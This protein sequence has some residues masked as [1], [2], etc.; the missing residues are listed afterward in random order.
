MKLSK[1]ELLVS[2]VTIIN[3]SSVRQTTIETFKEHAARIILRVEILEFYQKK[4]NSWWK[5]ARFGVGFGEETRGDTKRDGWFALRGVQIMWFWLCIQYSHLN[6]NLLWV[7]SRLKFFSFR[8][9]FTSDIFLSVE[10]GI[11][12]ITCQL[13]P[14]LFN[15]PQHHHHCTHA[16]YCLIP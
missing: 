5:I 16:V 8:M 12:P 15:H 6:F 3:C 1:L 7:S 9:L 11:F 14:I 2:A 13:N 10:R 4:G